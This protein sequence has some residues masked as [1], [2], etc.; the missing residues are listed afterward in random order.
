MIVIY[1]LLRNLSNEILR[2]K[3]VQHFEMDQNS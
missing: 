1:K 3:T 2:E